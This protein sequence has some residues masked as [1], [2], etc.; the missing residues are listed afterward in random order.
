MDPNATS[1]GFLPKPLSPNAPSQSVH[2]ADDGRSPRS[3]FAVALLLSI[4]LGASA[5]DPQLLPPE[6]AFRFSARAL[7]DR[8]VEAT[9]AVADGYYLYREKLRFSSSP[10]SAAMRAVALPAG[11]PKED[12][13][14]GKVDTYRGTVVVVLPLAAP[15][16][17]RSVTVVADSQGCADV[18]VCYPPN[19]QRVTLLLPATGAG[20]GLVVEANPRKKSWF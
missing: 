6:Q 1:S 5:A 10:E 15:L 17:G 19:Q 9:F 8:T 11:K 7:D 16:T 14:F 4:S 13:F 2:G 18:G 20:P 3:S 12:P